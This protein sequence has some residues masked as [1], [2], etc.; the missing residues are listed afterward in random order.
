MS[1]VD[2]SNVCPLCG[3]VWEE[4]DFKVYLGEKKKETEVAKEKQDKIDEA[5]S[6]IKTKVD[7]I[8][9]DITSLVKAHEQFKLEVIDEE[10]LKKYL[11]LLDSW[12]E[13]MTKPLEFF[14]SDKW[15]A[16]PLEDVFRA[17]FWKTKMLAPLEDTLKKVGDRFTKQQ[18]AWDT[19]TKM[20]DKWKGYQQ[21]QERKE[22][23]EVFKKRAEASLGYFEKARDSVLEGIYDAV[24]SNFNEYYKTIHFEDEDSFVS[25]ISPVKAQLIFE[26]D[27]YGRGMFPPHALHSEGHQDCMGLCLF[28]ALNKY[29]TKDVIKIIVLDD[30]IMSI[31]RTHRRA[32]C[33]LLKKVFSDKQ[34]IITTHDT[35]WAK[36]LKAEGIVTQKNMIHFVNWNIDTGPIF[37]LDKDLWDRIKEDLDKN[38]VPS[39][40]HKLRR[41]A[42][43]FFENI[44][45]FLSAEHLPYKGDHQW[46]LGDYARAAISTYKGYIKKAKSNF[47][48][49]KQKDKFEKLNK[50]EKKAN[51]IIAKSQIEQWII[52]ENVHYNRWEEFTKKDFEPVVKAFKNLF[53]LFTCSSCGAT[54]AISRRKGE[55][56]KT[57]VSCNCGKIF[58]NI[59]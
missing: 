45:D 38:D 3:R 40:A 10:E 11:S 5:S 41:D 32:V 35:A 24:K 43:F 48:K 20:E 59:E 52:N 55:T 47:Q 54:I 49:M 4:G 6:F 46:E 9:N 57:I 22:V 18:V 14:E 23:S 27:F 21:A 34:F 51:E 50:F 16:S 42:E 30:V 58:W 37:E 29:L 28:F 17:P 26:V 15:P 53:D 39:A 31:D 19:L 36:Q 12:S 44:C 7:L 8:K 56:S 33:H 1:L 25:K 2:E 13:V